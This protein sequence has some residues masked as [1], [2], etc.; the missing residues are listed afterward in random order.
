MKVI[1]S[2]ISIL[3]L[4]MIASSQSSSILLMAF[5]H[6]LLIFS[7]QTLACPMKCGIV[8]KHTNG[9]DNDYSTQHYD[10]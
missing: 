9:Y 10:K 2:L 8:M 3:P 6:L 1:P 4:E 7:K 5:I